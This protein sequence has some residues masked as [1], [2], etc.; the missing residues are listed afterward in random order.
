MFDQ[1]EQ[2]IVTWQIGQIK[3]LTP[4][5]HGTVNRT[6]A[7]ETKS[8]QFVLRAY[9]H[10]SRLPIK[11]EHEVIKFVGQRGIP[12][13]NPIPLPDGSTIHEL[14]GCFYALFPF[15]PGT[16]IDRDA[17]GRDEAVAIGHCLAEL[18]RAL[19]YFPHEQA[20]RRMFKARNETTLEQVAQ[21]EQA[22]AAL[23]ERGDDE[24]HTLATLDGMRQYILRTAP[25]DVPIDVLPLQ[26]IHGDFQERNLFFENNT[27]SAI[28]DWDQTYLAPR[29]WEVLRAMHF[30]WNF[31]PTP[32]RAFLEAYQA[33]WPLA[34]AELEH[35]ARWYA[36]SRGH[37][38]WVYQATYLEGN[39]R[40]RQFISRGFEPIEP[41]WE[42]V[43]KQRAKSEKA[44]SGSGGM[45][46][47]GGNT[48]NSKDER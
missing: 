38:L 11:R 45:G 14:N 18:H 7:V 46:E 13:L 41:L 5:A 37:N 10:T 9:R 33:T 34:R 24:R 22:I 29:G 30:V 48:L 28:I 40:T 44:E 36:F 21:I 4:I 3:A 27:I 2:A 35:A 17:L 12:V 47:S 23:P 39:S 6:L 25:P 43:M 16:Q 31:D 15:A 19:E 20:A 8:G 26:L 42:R 1:D 32:C